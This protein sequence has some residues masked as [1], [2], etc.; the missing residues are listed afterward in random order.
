ME[1]GLLKRLSRLI[2]DNAER[3]SLSYP[4]I[5]A[6]SFSSTEDGKKLAEDEEVVTTIMGVYIL[7]LGLSRQKLWKKRIEKKAGRQQCP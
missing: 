7:G 1:E 6:L 2:G 5:P 4:R 3:K